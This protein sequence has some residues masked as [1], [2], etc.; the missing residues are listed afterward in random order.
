[1]KG[2]QHHYHLLWMIYI[3]DFLQ[4]FDGR[5]GVLG[6]A[7]PYFIKTNSKGY[8]RPIAGIMLFDSC[9]VWWLRQREI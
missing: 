1:M 2:L 3:R 4:P 7:G 9:N 5:G 6:M 8:K